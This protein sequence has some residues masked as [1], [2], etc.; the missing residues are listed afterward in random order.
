MKVLILEDNGLPQF[1]TAPQPYAE[2]LEGVLTSLTEEYGQ[3]VTVVERAIGRTVYHYAVFAGSPAP[4][5][6]KT[7]KAPKANIEE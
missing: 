3:L 5:T 2:K 6:T 7:T 4:K 1:A